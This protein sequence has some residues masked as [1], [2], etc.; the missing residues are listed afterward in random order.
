MN[1]QSEER[2]MERRPR[3]V[4][5]GMCNT[6][7]PEIRF[8]AQMVAEYGGEPIIMDLGLGAAVD[9]A[10]VS[11][12][13][14]LAAAGASIDEVFAAPR[15]TAIKVVG[16]AGAL[17]ILE[18]HA[19]G[20]CD[21]IL[22]WAGSVGT[23]T[24]TAVMRALPFGVPKI[25]LT[26]MAASDVRM[27]L[28][29]KDIYIASPTVEQGINVVT[30][31][32]VANAAAAVVAM[33]KVPEVPAGSKPLAAL[34]SYGTTT[35][36]VLRC[37]EFMAARG[38]ETSIFHAVG[39]GA[40]MEDLIRS[41]LIGAVYD[42]T[43]G[44]LTN[45]M[46]GSAYGVPPT[47]EGERLTAA[48]DVGVPQVVAPGG[49][50]QAAHGPLTGVPQRYLDDIKNERR[51]SYRG[52][53]LP[54]QHNDSVTILPITLEEI[55]LLSAQIAERLNRATGPTQ[56]FMPMQGW[57]AYDQSEELASRERGWSEGNGA[58]P[59]WEPDPDQP[60]WSIKAT[61]MLAVLRKAFDGT[62]PNLDLLVCDMHILDVEFAAL[63]N[64][65]MGD[66]LDG[67]WRKGLYR[68][69]EGVLDPDRA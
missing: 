61:R 23:T 4:C 40:T 31:K 14:V 19:A 48:A 45:T 24:V 62:N 32:A 26:D 65:C 64:R 11:L 10:D 18:L 55:D 22:S 58:G 69:A 9:W 17:K 13:E 49:L 46:V 68:D 39:P 47:W 15:A 57:S 27:W 53:G 41:G 42:I 63:L 37:Q 44:E 6:K 50:D 56:F 25:M 59:L 5:A 52:S 35:P 20:R 1:A 21:G 60:R 3:I 43:L 33:A 16:H 38:W 7:G 34:T 30:R 54:Y 66:M 8:L 12:E 29:N 28:G 67:V 2:L 36:T 51:P